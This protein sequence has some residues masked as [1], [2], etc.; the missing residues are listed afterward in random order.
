MIPAFKGHRF[1][2]DSKLGE[3]PSG[4]H[5]DRCGLKASLRPDGSVFFE[6]KRHGVFL[7]TSNTAPFNPSRVPPCKGWTVV[8]S[9]PV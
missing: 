5:C 2:E 8:H 6:I 3:P 1:V 9:R 4:H 7:R